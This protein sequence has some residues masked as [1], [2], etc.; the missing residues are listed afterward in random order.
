VAP[1]G[2]TLT[3]DKSKHTY[4]LTGEP[5]TAGE[6]V[7]VAGKRSKGSSGLDELNV[8]AVKKDLGQCQQTTAMAQPNQ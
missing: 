8:V 7:S 5:I 2:K 3:A 4:Q 6:H 1:D